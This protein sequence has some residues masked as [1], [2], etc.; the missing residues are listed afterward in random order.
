MVSV[1]DTLCELLAVAAGGDLIR[2]AEPWSLTEELRM[3][4]VDAETAAG[5]LAAL[6]GLARRA[7]ASDWRLYC[8]WAL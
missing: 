3:I 6:A 1:S 4:G 2:A 5:V 8:W 7:R